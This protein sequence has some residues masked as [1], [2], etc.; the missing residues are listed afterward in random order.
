MPVTVVN[1]AHVL[2]HLFLMITLGGVDTFHFIAEE[3]KAQGLTCPRKVTQLIH[4][5]ARNEPGHCGSN[6]VLLPYRD[7]M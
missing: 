4:A 5:K 1:V 3:T 6:A 7:R 2:T